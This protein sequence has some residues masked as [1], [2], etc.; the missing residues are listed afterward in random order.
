M[1]ISYKADLIDRCTGI[2]R[3]CRRIMSLWRIIRA[4]VLPTDS[5]SFWGVKLCGLLSID[6]YRTAISSLDLVVLG[7]IASARC[8]SWVASS[9]H[10]QGVHHLSC[11]PSTFSPLW[12]AKSYVAWLA[13]WIGRT[14]S[15]AVLDTTKNCTRVISQIPT[16]GV[17]RSTRPEPTWVTSVSLSLEGA[18]SLL[19][20]S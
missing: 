5:A 16:F 17:V 20:R 18:A 2:H 7:A 6:E 13:M 8:A 12:R 3:K 4:W 14:C 15:K 9:T 1:N 10:L 19:R 11:V